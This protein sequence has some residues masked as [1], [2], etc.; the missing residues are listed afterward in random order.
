MGDRCRWPARPGPV[1]RDADIW[2]QQGD[3]LALPPG[4]S[5]LLQAWPGAD[6]MLMEQALA[7][8]PRAAGARASSL[9][10]SLRARLVRWAREL[11][12]LLPAAL[13]GACTAQR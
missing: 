3:S 11:Q 7:P 1:P 13:G 8:L 6:L 9:A 5:W 4:S 10:A 12:G 2:L